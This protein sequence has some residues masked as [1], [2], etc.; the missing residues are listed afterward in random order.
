VSR[1]YRLFRNKKFLL[2]AL[3]SFG[4]SFMGYSKAQASYSDPKT[5]LEAEELFRLA[6]VSGLYDGYEL[7]NAL[8]DGVPYKWLV[9]C[10]E[11]KRLTV[12]QM[13]TMFENYLKQNPKLL[14]ENLPFLYLKFMRNS[15]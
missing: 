9:F 6:Y 5:F 10:V 1:P 8:G 13:T 12:G 2:V 14:E 4:V 7:A 15:C 3:L 11:R